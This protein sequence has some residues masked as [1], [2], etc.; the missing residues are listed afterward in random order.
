LLS[1][2]PIALDGAACSNDPE[3]HPFGVKLAPSVG[4]DLDAEVDE[5]ADSTTTTLANV[6][7]AV[8]HI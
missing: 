6:V 3:N 4:I 7:I 8:R 1:A 2:E 5:V